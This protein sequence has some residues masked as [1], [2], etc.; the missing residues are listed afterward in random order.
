MKQIPTTQYI[1]NEGA[2]K[3]SIS[4]AQGVTIAIGFSSVFSLA[5]MKLGAALIKMFQIIEILGRF[6]Y[7]PIYFQGLLLN[8]L[9]SVD[10]LSSLVSLPSDLIFS[11]EGAQKSR[12][13]M[14]FTIYETMEN[15]FQSELI[16]ALAHAVSFEN[17]IF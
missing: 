10:Q 14:K 2:V 4:T 9:Y 12:Y 15:V 7:F 17:G 11:S 3:T 16:A 8:V 5:A 1:K 6:L 13:W